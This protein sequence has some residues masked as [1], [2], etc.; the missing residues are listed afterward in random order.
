[1]SSGTMFAD[2]LTEIASHG[3]LVVANGDPS[4]VPGLAG[5][6]L[7][8]AAGMTKPQML[9]DS[10]DWVTKGGASKYGDID[11][12][13]IAAA[14]QS[15]GGLEVRLTRADLKICKVKLTELLGLLRKLS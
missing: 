14:G 5:G 2:F 7:S 10:V 11:T 4:R 3:Y 9:T 8:L 15:C 12:T 6:V 1:M 13:K